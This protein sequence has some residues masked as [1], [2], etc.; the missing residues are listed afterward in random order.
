MPTPALIPHTRDA[1]PL[2]VR[3]LNNP[4][5]ARYLYGTEGERRT[6]L[7]EQ[8]TWFSR[9]EQD[10]T[11]RLFTVLLE[12]R[13]IGIVGLTDIDRE[14]GVAEAFIMIGEDDAVGKGYG[15]EALL[16]LADEARRSFSLKRIT[17]TIHRENA[18]AIACN[19]SAGFTLA[20]SKS[21]DVEIR[22]VKELR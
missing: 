7:A 13:P 6:T 14:R 17:A 16:L 3:W 5:V 21:D 10:V 4:R 9:Y 19:L 11:R 22:M 20:P 15:K 1:L 8:D 18:P 2:R 12:T